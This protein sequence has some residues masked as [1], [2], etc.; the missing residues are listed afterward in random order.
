M[1]NGLGCFLVICINIVSSITYCL[2]LLLCYYY[3]TFFF[4]FF[5]CVSEKPGEIHLDIYLGVT[6]FGS[7]YMT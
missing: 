6:Q 3:I 2:L 5:T 4:F 1:P 7:A